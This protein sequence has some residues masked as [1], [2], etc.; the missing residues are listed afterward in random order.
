MEGYKCT[1]AASR[2]KNWENMVKSVPDQNGPQTPGINNLLRD[3]A[4]WQVDVPQTKTIRWQIPSFSSTEQ[5]KLPCQT[6]WSRWANMIVRRA[7]YTFTI[8]FRCCQ[9]FHDPNPTSMGI[10]QRCS[11][12][13]ACFQTQFLKWWSNNIY[14]HY[15]RRPSPPKWYSYVLCWMDLKEAPLNINLNSS[16]QNFL[17]LQQLVLDQSPKNAQGKL[18]FGLLANLERKRHQRIINRKKEQ[19]S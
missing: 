3:T 10:N 15:A 12:W 9:A 18:H 16:V 17:P 4:I 2:G 7:S 5:M 14:L 13:S 6:K 19:K 11:Y 1:T 8:Q